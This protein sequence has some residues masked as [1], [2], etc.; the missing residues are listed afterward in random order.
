MA[1]L[2][3]QG[4]ASLRLISDSGVVVY[5]DPFAGKGYDEKADIILVTHQ[6][7]DHK[8]INKPKHQSDCTIIQNFDAL[9][10]GEYHK[11]HIK[12]INIE[13]VPAYNKN[14]PR[15]ECVGFLVTIDEILCYFSGDTSKIIE[16]HDLT[17]RNIEYAFFCADGVFNMD[18]VEASDCAR[19]VGAA[20][21]TPIHMAPGLLFSEKK[22]AEF[23]AA[24]FK[25][26]GKLV[27]KPGEEIRLA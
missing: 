17:D 13:A 11:F 20:H 23:K 9:K 12:G 15:K 3:Y 18:A 16:M 24:E 4:H 6:H 22:A 27:M 1:K 2:L 5:I 7:L 10:D 14:H 26:A 21:S 25:A 8:L 19:I